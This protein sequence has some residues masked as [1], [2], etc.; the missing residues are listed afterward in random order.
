MDINTVLRLLVALARLLDIDVMTLAAMFNDGAGNQKYFDALVRI[1]NM[2]PH[3][4][5]A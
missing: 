5:V 4:Y 2:A 1:A 3:N